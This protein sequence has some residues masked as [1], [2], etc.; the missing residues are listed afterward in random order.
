MKSLLPYS[1]CGV[2]T[3]VRWLHQDREVVGSDP[4]TTE[5]FLGKPSFPLLMMVLAWLF[6]MGVVEKMP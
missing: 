5:T 2:V 4:A 1:S 6:E 3:V